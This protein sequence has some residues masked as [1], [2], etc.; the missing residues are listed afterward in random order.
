MVLVEGERLLFVILFLG[1]FVCLFLY[2]ETG[3]QIAFE[4]PTS[5][6]RTSRSSVS[7]ANNFAFILHKFGWPSFWRSPV[8]KYSS[9]V[10]LSRNYDIVYETRYKI[11]DSNIKTRVLIFNWM[12]NRVKR[13]VCVSIS[14]L[15]IIANISCKVGHKE[16]IFL[17]VNHMR[18][19]VALHIYTFIFKVIQYSKQWLSESTQGKHIA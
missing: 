14:L 19:Y 7:R 16:Y 17:T 2:D 3:F 6:T 1:F 15:L 8:R 12:T 13:H 11:L 5:P 18:K 4:L 10:D 9:Q